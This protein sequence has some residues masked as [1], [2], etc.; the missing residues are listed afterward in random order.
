MT[1]ATNEAL[2][3]AD[4]FEVCPECGGIFRLSAEKTHKQTLFHADNGG[5]K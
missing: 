4:G 5:S 2:Y 1:K 3:R